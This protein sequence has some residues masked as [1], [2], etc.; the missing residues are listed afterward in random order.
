MM[1]L[2]ALPAKSIQTR[3]SCGAVQVHQM[4]YQ[5]WT[6]PWFGSTGSA[7]APASDPWAET[8]DPPRTTRLAK[9]SFAG[10]MMIVTGAE[11]VARPE[12]VTPQAIIVCSPTGGAVQFK[13]RGS[14]VIVPM[15]FSPSR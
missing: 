3:P 11:V 5:G 6:Y 15:T 8:T 2:T 12:P 9:S 4:E 7:L 10:L 14:V 13:E 1:G